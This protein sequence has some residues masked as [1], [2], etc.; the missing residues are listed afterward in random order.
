M[1]GMTAVGRRAD[2]RRRPS[3]V[4]TMPETGLVDTPG[5]CVVVVHTSRAVLYAFAIT[6]TSTIMAHQAL[7][8]IPIADRPAHGP[9]FSRVLFPLVFNLGQIGIFTSQVLALPL[10]LIPF[11]G[12]K[13]FREV[14][15]YTKDGYGRLRE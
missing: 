10:L 5:L 8:T 12:S 14:V 7:H 9:W 6:H 1:T 2:E 15:D 4:L 3:F 11:V 13:A